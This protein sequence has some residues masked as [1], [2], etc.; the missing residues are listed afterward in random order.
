MDIHMP[1]MDGISA[2]PII[3]RLETGAPV[4]AM[5]ANIMTGDIDQYKAI[6]MSDYIGKPFTA[7]ELWN[8]LLKFLTPVEFQN[9]GA[10]ESKEETDLEKQLK[11]D[12]VRDNQTR[13]EEI[14]N[15]VEAGDITLAH[16]LAHTLKSNA[17]LVGRPELHKAA[18]NI[19]ASL[20]GGKNLATAE[21]ME[22]LRGELRAALDDLAPYFTQAA[23]RRKPETGAGYDAEKARGLI[24]KLEPLLKAGN[25]ECL[26]LVDDLYSIPGTEELIRQI[27][28]LYFDAAAGLLTSLKEKL[29]A[30]QWKIK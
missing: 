7:Q 23:A 15:A 2:T 19:E 26:K 3:L 21:Q 22:I 9:M 6:G 29:E 16:R 5:T 1:V 10:A 25:P 8:C 24:E 11:A 27:D 4:V 12:F 17:A 30:D 18:A 13:Y 28:D 20:K 14:I